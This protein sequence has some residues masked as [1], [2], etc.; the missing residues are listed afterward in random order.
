M[1]INTSDPTVRADAKDRAKRTVVQGLILDMAV[2]LGLAVS[3]WVVDVPDDTLPT[4]AKWLVLGIAVGKSV[5][6]AG[7]SWLMRLKVAP[8]VAS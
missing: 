4:G 7:V 8:E 5:V 1:T 3:T 6:Q 2:A